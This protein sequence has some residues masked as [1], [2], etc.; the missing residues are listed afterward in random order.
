MK[1]SKT[2]KGFQIFLV[3]RVED[4]MVCWQKDLTLTYFFNGF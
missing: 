1:K 3:L 4:L 2:K